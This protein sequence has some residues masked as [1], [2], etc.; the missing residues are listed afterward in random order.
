[1]TAFLIVGAV[2]C[3]QRNLIFPE[4]DRDYCVTHHHIAPAVAIWGP[5]RNS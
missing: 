2:R 1:M 5:Q 4:K 3:V